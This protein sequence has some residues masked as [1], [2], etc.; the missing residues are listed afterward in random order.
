MHQRESQSW[1][2]AGKVLLHA[3]LLSVFVLVFGLMIQRHLQKVAGMRAFYQHSRQIAQM[4]QSQIRMTQ[5]GGA[6]STLG[7]SNLRLKAIVTGTLPEDFESLSNSL[8]GLRDKVG[9]DIVY[10]MNATGRVVICTPYDGGKR[11]TGNNYAFRPYF[12][13]ALAGQAV[14]YG[15]LGATTFQRGL[16]Y[17]A[18]I[19]ANLEG[20]IMTNAVIGV[21]VIKMPFRDVDALMSDAANIM[22]LVNPG[23]IVFSSSISDWQLQSIPVLA[24]TP[25]GATGTDVHPEYESEFFK[26]KSTVLPLSLENSTTQWQGSNFAVKTFPVSLDDPAGDW[27][28]LVLQNTAGWFPI[29][30]VLLMALLLAGLSLTLSF[31]LHA[32]QRRIHATAARMKAMLDAAQTYKSIFNAT[33]DSLFVHDADS[34]AILDANESA[35]KL[36]GYT[37]SDLHTLSPEGDYPYPGA[38]ATS[39][40]RQAMDNRTQIITFESRSRDQRDFWA[41]ATFRPCTIHGTLRVLANVHD[42][43]E[44]RATHTALTA[45]KELLEQEVENR[46]SQ[47]LQIQKMAAIGKFAERITHDVTNAMTRII[48]YADMIRQRPGDTAIL[49]NSLTEINTAARDMCEFS[50]DLLAFAHPSALK[51][52]PVNLTRVISSFQNFL[53]SSAP[54]GIEIIFQ[55]SKER[56]MCNL[57]PNH[58]EQALMHLSM[59]C[60]EA[61][62]D[63]G[64]LT[65]TL[66]RGDADDRPGSTHSDYSS[67]PATRLAL[68]EITDT[69]TGIPPEHLSNVFDPFFTTKKDSNRRGMGLTT[70]YL[71]VNR[72]NGLVKM[73]PAAGGTGNTAQIWLPLIADAPGPL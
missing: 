44:Q 40:I 70:V 37:D 67:T 6:V 59:N 34:G 27:T 7:I 12:Q 64:T 19:Y 50:T 23:G 31:L 14:V 51:L 54:R 63:G 20:S 30:Q 62:E 58:I 21:F 47:L 39:A 1:V 35:K 57:S 61:M 68:I 48:G 45:S 38:V 73:M 4:L 56:L 8:I 18:P 22:C 25:D 10:A 55:I 42:I 26:A 2:A 41:Q 69:G 52:S 46:T 13:K 15:A 65:I 53:R 17:A 3:L 28:L 16:Y 60:F 5:A 72:H 11:L 66:R 49:N 43:T 32:R 29:E 33:S 9:A 36:Y 71:I 24:R